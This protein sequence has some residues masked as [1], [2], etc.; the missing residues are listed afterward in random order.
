MGTRLKALRKSRGMTQL[1]AAER[2]GISKAMVSSY[3]LSARQPSYGVL[4]KLA[5]LYGVTTDYLLGAE[6]D[7]VISV[8]G[9]SESN[10][11]LI[12]DLVKA[13]KSEPRA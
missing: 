4:V 9:L 5:A 11:A 7:R 12:N 8:D 10:I 2:I 3:E 6:R 1:Q 13:L